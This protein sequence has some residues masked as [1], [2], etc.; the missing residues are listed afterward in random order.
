MSV[1][2]RPCTVAPFTLVALCKR[3]HDSRS[4]YAETRH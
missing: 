4:H 1:I 3:R 2:N